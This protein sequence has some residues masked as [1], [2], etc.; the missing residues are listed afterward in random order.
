MVQYT[1]FWSWCVEQHVNEA[2]WIAK[3]K[4]LGVSHNFRECAQSLN[5]NLASELSS[6]SSMFVHRTC[7]VKQMKIHR[8]V[9]LHLE[10]CFTS[11]HAILSALEIVFD[12]TIVI[13]DVIGPSI[14]GSSPRSTIILASNQPHPTVFRWAFNT[15]SLQM[16]YYSISFKLCVTGHRPPDSRKKFTHVTGQPQTLLKKSHKFAKKSDFSLGWHLGMPFAGARPLPGFDVIE[17]KLAS[18]LLPLTFVA[19]WLIT[20]ICVDM[21]K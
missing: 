15:Y 11:F 17:S 6:T 1:D 21:A 8:N 10:I 9:W 18:S 19:R 20:G 5:M 12:A 14:I 3:K 2:F 7:I 16:E 13:C 4:S